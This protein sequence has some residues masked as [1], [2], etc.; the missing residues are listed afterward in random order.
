[1]STEPIQTLR[2]FCTREGGEIRY[3]LKLVREGTTPLTATGTFA[4]FDAETV[5]ELRWYLEDYLVEGDQA[6]EARADQVRVSIRSLGTA[7]FWEIFEGTDQA[8]AVLAELRAH[9]YRTRVQVLEGG[10]LPLPLWELLRDPMTGIPL[11]VA[12]FTFVRGL[13]ASAVPIVQT[14]SKLRILLVISRPGRRADVEFRTIATTLFEGLQTQPLFEIDVLRPP[15]FAQLGDVLRKASMAGRS[16]DLVHFD[17]H[18]FYESAASEGGVAASSYLLFEDGQEGSVSV[19]GEEF[20]ELIAECGVSTV[21]LNACRSAHEEEAE[22]QTGDPAARLTSLSHR[23][24]LSGVPSVVAMHFNVYVA[25]AKRFMEEFYR[26]LSLRKPFS[27]AACQARKHLASDGH[28]FE[29]DPSTID[30]WLVPA[31]YQSGADLQVSSASAA[32]TETESCAL[33]RNMPPAPDLGFV[34]S[35]DTLLEIDRAFDHQALVLLYGLAGAGKSATAAEFAGWYRATNNAIHRVLFSSFEEPPRLAE[36]VANVAAETGWQLA[37]AQATQIQI[38]EHL[39]R[40]LAGAGTLWVWDNVETIADLPSEFQSD[41]RRFSQQADVYG[42]KILLT[43]RG[44][45]HEWLDR[46][47]VPVEMKP[48]R[49]PESQDLTRRALASR[50]VSRLDA[51]LF[52]PIIAFADGNPLTLTLALYSYL[53]N[54]RQVT[55]ESV[56]QYVE[57]LQKGAAMLEADTGQGRTSS[58]TASLNYGFDRGLTPHQRDVL[59]LLSLFRVYINTYSLWIMCRPELSREAAGL[60]DHIFSWG[61]SEFAAETSESLGELLDRAVTLGLLRKSQPFNFWLHPAVHLHLRQHLDRCFPGSDSKRPQ[62]AYAETV[63][64]F[65]I[66]FSR[67]LQEGVRDPVVEALKKEQDNLRHA[68]RLS[69]DNGWWQAE[70][71][72]LHGLWALLLHQGRKA[73][74]RDLFLSV[75]GDFV[76]E[77]WLPLPG[78]ESWWSFVAD[79]RLRIAMEDQETALMESLAHLLLD[80]EEGQAATVSREPGARYDSAHRQKLLNLAIATGRLADVLRI[81]GTPGCVARNLDAI[82]LF[83]L[84]DYPPGIAIRH[85][86]LG[87]A[88]KNLPAIKDLE[89]AKESYREALNHYPEQDRLARAQALAQLG[90]VASETL[91]ANSQQGSHDQEK[92]LG[93]LNESIGWFEKALEL[94]PPDAY[95]DLS[96]AHNQLG[97]VLRFS[98]T[99]HERAVHHLREA[100]KLAASVEMYLEAASSRSNMAQILATMGRHGEAVAAASE[101]ITEFTRIGHTGQPVPHLERLIKRGGRLG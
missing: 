1:M 29:G 21:V 7:W 10:G 26:Q 95:G 19:S 70:V 85:L 59:S 62:R 18:G 82:R 87:H 17:G 58:L 44:G 2:L 92:L 80:Y 45:D 84:I 13:E 25:S 52:D 76:D 88:Y 20:A 93:L 37:I 61:L 98:A 31:I 86:N 60:P 67:L 55:A 78:R 71:G 90:T 69:H 5:T 64:L 50:N 22:D 36:L 33:P 56:G 65:A 30:D 94:I 66:Q 81:K 38:Q 89:K 100:A 35:N 42:L 39:I 53:A 83:E 32:G 24:L 48:L 72:I 14:R 6:A 8:R 75:V 27:V 73:A 47:V 40:I 12:A 54:A 96:L 49:Y 9:L 23:L 41:Y 77:H 16:Y 63:G 74:W 11:C 3:S 15:T 34:G 101:A 99:E 43:A 46:A 97:V 91:A 68:L 57:S 79:H 51:R 4:Q 28:R